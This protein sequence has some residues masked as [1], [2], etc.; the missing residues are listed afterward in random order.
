[1]PGPQKGSRI[2]VDRARWIAALVCLLL[3]VSS[4]HADPD[5]PGPSANLEL[6]PAGSLVIAMDNAK[7][8]VGTP[9]NLKAYGLVNDLLWAGIPVK[10][11]IRAGKA[12]D[13]TDFTVTAQRIYPSAVAAASLN[14]SAGPFIIHRDWAYYAKTRIAA[15]GNSVAVY[16]TTQDVTVDIRHTLQFRPKIAVLNDGGNQNIHTTYLSDAG[17]VATTHYVTISATTLTTIN[18]DICITAASEPHWSDTPPDT[19]AAVQAVLAFLGS[20]GNFLAECDGIQ[21]YENNPTYGRYQSTT[22]I[23]ENSLSQSFLYPNPD[24]PISQFD[25]VLVNQGGSIG[26]FALAAGSSWRTRTYGIAQD[27]PTTSTYAATATKLNASGIGSIAAYLGGHSYDDNSTDKANGRR[28]YL[29]WV[30]TPSARPSSCGL[31]MVDEFRQISGRVY[32]DVNGDGNLGDGVNAANVPI[33]IYADLN[34]N[35]V[36]DTGDTYIGQSATLADGT[37]SL[38][39]NKVATGNNYVVVVDS[40]SIVP[41]GGYNGGFAIGDVWAEQTYGDDPTTAALDVAAR[42]GGASGTVSDNFNP[43]LAAVASNS[44]QHVARVSVASGD[45]PNVNFGFS[46]N[47]VVNTRAGDAVDD[48]ATANRTVQ[49]SFRQFLRNAN[50]IAGAN[51]M[52][53]TPAVATNATGGGGNWWRIS[54]TTALPALS[55]ANT[56]ID[57]RAYSS[58]DGTTVRDDNSGTLGTGGTAGTG[59]LALSTLAKPEFEIQD[60]RATAVIPVGLDIQGS[61]N[62]IRRIGILGFGAASDSANDSDIRIGASALRALVEDNLIGTAASTF[63]DAGAGIRSVGDHIRSSGGDTGIIR[64]NLIGFG[65]GKGVGLSTASDGWLVEG[66]EI[67]R[68]AIGN[69]ALDGVDV[70]ASTTATVRGNLIAQTDGNGIDTNASTGS[71]T[72]VNNT[73]TGNGIGAAALETSGIRIFGAGS[74]IDRNIVTANT[75]A[76]VLVTVAATTNRITHNSIS[77]NGPSNNQIGIDLLLAG[78]DA[79]RGTSPFVS[80]NDNT[81]P[82]VGGNNVLNYPVIDTA[83]IRGTDLVLRGWARPGSIIELF[84]AAPDPSNFGEGQT[85]LI[86]LTEGSGADTDATSSIFGPGAVNGIVQG[87]DNTNRFRFVIPIASLTTPVVDGTRIT[88]TATDGS[89]NTSEFSGLGTVFDTKT[90][91][92]VTKTDGVTSAIPGNSITY[93]ITVTNLGPHEATGA[94]LTDTFD[95][96]F[97]TVAGVSWTCAITTGSGACGAASGTGNISTGVDLTLNSVATFT[98]TA[99]IKPQ[100]TG[101]ISNTAT[102]TVAAG[103]IDP[104]PG[105]N[106]ATDNNTVL[107]VTAN[108]SITKTDGVVTAIPG[109]SVT[110]TLV[111]GN[112]GPSTAVNA[113]VTDTFNPAMFNVAGVSWT[114]VIAGSGSCGAASGTGNIATT[115]TLDPSATATYTVTAPILSGATGTLSNTATVAAPAG[116][117]DPVAGNNS[118]TDNNTVLNPSSDLSITKTDG[119]NSAIPGQSIT[120]TIVVSNAG[121][122]DTVNASVTDALNPVQFNLPGTSWTCAVTGSGSCGAAS[123]TGSIASTVSLTVGSSATYTVTAPIRANATGTL[124]NTATVAAP[125][126]ASDP[127]AGNNSATDNN[128]VLNV[129]SDLSI[130]KTDGVV[131]AVPGQ[132]VTYTIVVSNAGPSNTVNAPVADTFNPA[133]FNVAGV[134]WTCAITGTGSC[135]AASGTGN[136]ATTVSLSPGSS[137]TYTVTAPILANATGTL[138]N[139]A[140][141][142]APAGS[143]DPAAGNNSATDNNTVL[144]VT[145]DLSITK[146]DGVASATPGQSVTYTIVVANGGPSNVVNAAVADT[147]NASFFNVAGVSWTCAI[148]GTGSCGAASGTGNIATTVSLNSGSSATYTVTAPILASATGTLSNTATV[149]APGGTTDPAAGN[150]SATDNNT[151]LSPVADLSITKTDGVVS[152][153]A[154]QSVTYTIVVSNAGPSS[155]VNAPVADTF[156]PAMFNVGGVSWTCA[157]SGSGS[158][159]AASGSGNIATTASIAPGSTATYTVTAPILAAATGTLSNTA[160]V[161]APGGT[162]D[163]VAGNNSATDNN[164]VLSV[165]SD[166]SITKTDG[167]VSAVAGQSVTYT[168]VV[169]NAGPSSV[170]NAPVADTFNPAMFNVAGVSWTCAITGTGSC[171]AASGTGNIATTVSLAPGSSATY[172]VTAPILASATGTLSNT[173]TVSAPGGTTDPVNGNNSATDNNTVLTG[174]ADL[175]I[176]KTDGVASAIPGQSVTYTLVVSNAGPSTVVGAAVTDTF[177]PTKFNVAAVSWTCATSGGGS[178][179]AASGTGNLATTASLPPGATAT[180]TMTAPILSAATGTLSNTASVAAPAGTNDPNGGNNSATD[181]NTALQVTTDLSVVKSDGV[182]TAV[183]GQSVTY[184]ITVANAGPSNAV[185]AAVADTFNPAMFNVGGVS[186][187][188]AITGSGSCGAASGTGNIATTVS[189]TAGSSATYTVTV[190]ILANA[191]GTLSNT[192]TVAAAGGTTDPVAGNNS[193]TDNNTALQATSNLAIT[194]DD[195]AASYLPGGTTIYTITVTNAGPSDAVDAVVSDPVT[196]LPEVASASWTCAGHGGA[197]CTAGPV[198]GVINDTVDIPVGGTVIYTLT[199]ITLPGATTNLVNTATVAAGN[200]GVDPSNGDNSDTDTDTKGNGLADVSIT[201][202]DGV[203]TAVAGQSVTYTIVV[204]NAGP[205]DVTAADVTDTFDPTWFNV[206]GV[207]WTC[208][209][210]GTGACAAGAGSGNIATT[211]DLAAGSTATFTVTAPILSGATGTIVNTAMVLAPS[212]TV[213]PNHGNDAATDNNTVL[214]RI[215]DL[216]ITKTDGVASAV[217]GQSVTYTIVV[218]NAGPSNVTN[219]AVADTFNPAMFNVAGESWTCAVTGSG[220]CGAASGT[221]NIATT[222]SLT[223]GSSATYTVTAPILSSATGTL[224]NTATVAAPGG[225]TDPVAGNNSATD[226]NTALSVTADLS[227]TK[228]DGVASAVP[229]QSVTYTIVVAN[230]G[231]S[232]VVNAPVADTFNPAMF[233]VAG[234]SW[235]CAVTGTGSCGAASGTGNIATTVSL[236]SGAS[237]TYTVT[238]P[239]LSIATGTLSNTA[240]VA[241]PSGATDAV[242][243]NNSATD[244]DTALSVTA[245]LSITKTDGVASAVPG[246]SVTYTIVVSNAGPSDAVNAAVADTFDPSFFNVGGVSW[247]CLVT[248]GGSCGAAS[249]TGNIATTVSL[250]SGSAATYTVTAPILS[251]ATGTPSNTATVAAPGGTTDPVAG[252]NSATDNNTVLSVTADLSIT[253]TDGVASAVPGQSVTYTIVVA[254]NGP[255]DVV[256]APVADT[257]DPT[258][259]NVAGVSWTCAT[260]GPGSCGAASGSGNIATTVSLA[261]G[262]SATYTVTAPILSNATGTLSNTATVTAPG[263]TTDPV[264][265]NNTATDN[266]TALSVTSD[267]SI[268]KTDGVASAVPGQSVTYTIVVANNGP[269]DVVNAPVADTFDPTKFNVAGV[270][271]TCTVTGTGSCGAASGTGNIATTV[272]LT[273]GSSATYTVTAP[274]LSSATGTLSNTATV[275]APAGTTDPAAGNNSATDNNTALSVTADLSI[276]KTDGVATAVPGQSVTYTIV[277]SNSGPSDVVNAPVADTFDA[278]KFNVAGVSWTCAV[279]GPGSCGAASGTGNI[280]STVTLTSGSSATYTVTA[281]ILA[282]ATGTLSNTAT[283]A[284]PGGTTDPVA[285]NNS[286]TD[287]DTA[288]SVTADLSITKTDG[289]ATAVPGQSVTYTIAVSNAGPSNVV[290]APVA[291]TLNPAMFNVGGSSWTCVVTGGGSCGAASGTGSIASTVDL[292]PGATA[293]YTV[294]VPILSGATG[295]LSNTA[296]VAAPGGTTDPVAGNNSATDNDTVLSVTADLAITKTDGVASAVPGQSVTYTIVVSNN[297]PSDVVNAAVADTFDPARFN[298]AGATWTCAVTG[299]GSCAAPSGTGNIATAVSLTSGSS[300]TYTVTVPILSSATGTL[301]NTATVTAPGGTTDPVAGNNSA[302]DNDTALSVTADLS[303]TKTDGVASAVPGQSVT[304]TIVVANAGPSDV[305]NAPVA[306]TF[307]PALFNIAGVSWTCAVT[308]TGSCGAASGTGNIASTVSLSSGSSATYTVTAPILSN[309]TGT[310]SNTATIAAPAGT[311]DPVAGNNSATD[312]DTALSVT[313]DLS[314]TK[315]DGVVSAVPGQSVTY[316]I[317]VS[318]AGPSDVINAPVADTF[319]PAMFNVAGVSWTCVVTGGGS[320]GAASG[321]GNIASTASLTSGSSA[322]YTVTAPILA[323]ATG[324]LSNTATITAPAGTIDPVAGNNSA[325]DNNTALSVTADLSIT[326]TDG[327]VSAMPGQTVTYTIVV[328]NAGPSNVVNATV[329]DVFAPALFNA[330]GASWTCA[331]TGTG[332]CGAASGAGNLAT[333]VSLTIGSSAT[334]TVTV[335]IL[336]AATGTLSNTATVAAPAGATDPVAG[337]NSATDNDTVL[338]VTADLSITKTDG[339]VS[340]VPGQSVTY[341]I[342][343]AN[344]GLS[345]VVNAAIADAFDP[346]K[347][348]VGAVSWTCA[349]TGTGACGAASGTGNIATTVS[350]T[351]GSSATYT[352]TAP[353]LSN[354]TGTLSNTATVAAP[355]GTT[356]PVAGNNTATDNDT[357]LSVT[358]DLSITKTDGV[359]SAVPGQTITYTIVVSNAGPSD[360]VNASVADAF[361]PAMFNVAGVS[362]TCAVTGTGAC[363]A[364]SGTG[365]IATTLSLTSSSSATYIVTVPILSQATGTL[366]N[367]A[368]VAAPAGTTDPVAGNN[369]AT[370]SD[371][372]LNGVADLSITKTDGVASAVPGQSVT[373]TIVVS[374]NGP[375]NVVGAPV[376]DTFNPAQFNVAGVSWTCAVAGAG[377]CSAA[378]GTGNIATSVDLA[379]GASATYTVTAPILP[380][381]TGTLANTATVATPAGTSD[382]AP[383]NNTATDNNTA[384]SVTADL[385]ITKTDGVVSAVPGQ[386]VTYTI[387][388]ANAGPSSVAAAPVTDTFNPAQFNVAG[389]SWTCAIAGVGAC[390]AA[391]GTGN[392]ATTVNLAPGATATYTVTAPIRSSATGTLSNTALVAAPAGTTDPVAGNNTATDN[393]TALSVTADLAI[394]KTDGVVAAVPGQSVTY[395][396]IVTNSGPSDVVNAAVADTFNPALFNVAGVSWTCAVTGTG[397][398]GAASGTGNIAT[399]VSLTSGSSATY[400]VTV[401]ILSNATGS[402]ANTATVTAPAGTTDPVAGNNSATDNDT[403]LNAA[404]DLSITKTDGVASAVPGQ[405]VTYTIVVSNAGPSSVVAAPVN[406]AFN[407]AQFNIAGISWTCAVTGTGSC[408]AASGTGNIATT[409]DLAPGAFATYTV[410]APILAS[411]TGT[412]SNTATVTAPP[413]TTDSVPG[414]NSATDNNTVLTGVADLSITKTDGVVSAVAGQ[415]VTY[416]IVVSNAGPSSVVA[417]PVADTFNPA[418]FNV[419]GVSWTCAITGTGACGAASGTGNLATTVDL[420]PGSSATYTVTAPI[421]PGATGTLSNTATVAA[422]AGTTDPVAGNNSATDNN[423]ALSVTADL[424]ITKT[425]G[426][427]T[428]APGQSVTYTIVV[429]NA[430]PSSVVGAPVTDTFNPVFFNVAG[431]SWTCAIAGTGACGAASGTGNIATTVDLAPGATATYTVTAPVRSNATGTLSN[432]ATV[433]VPVGTTDPVAGN[434]T[435]TDSNTV[436]SVTSDL[437]ITKT[438]GVVSAVPGQSVTFTIVVTNNGPSDVIGAPVADTFNPAMFDVASVSWTCAAGGGGACG[439]ASGTGNIATTVSLPTG[440]SATFTVNA[441]ILASATGTLSNTATVTAPIGTTDPVAGNNAATDNNTVL[442]GTSDLSITKTDGVVSAA[443]GQS[444]TYTIVVANAGPS[445]VTNAPI[446]DTF[447]PAQF[448][449]AAVSWTCAVTGTGS[450]AAASGTGNIATTVSLTTGSLATFT[451]TAPIL[452]TATGTLSNTATVGV[453]LGSVDPNLSNNSATDNNTALNVTADLSI[454]KTDGVVSAVP[455]QSVTY[456]IVVGNA[457]PSNIVAAPVTDPFNPAQFNV[458]GITWTCAITGTGACGAASGSGNIAT[459]V[460]LAPGATATYTVTAPILSAATGTLSNTAT[461]AL[462]PGTTDP[463]PGNNSATDNDTVLGVRADLSITK[464]DGVA[465]AVPGQSV[466]YTIVVA[467]AGPSDVVNANVADTLNPGWFNVAGATWTCAVTGTGACGA[468]SG[469]GNIATT[470]S[471]TSGSSA[472]YLVTVPIL[473]SATGTLSNT[474]TVTAPAGTTDPAAGN[475]SATD[476][477]TSLD[478]SFDLS[479]TKTDS[480]VSAVPGQTVTYT[481]VVSNAG[482]SDVVNAAV[483]DPFNPAVFNVAGVNWTCAITGGG[484]C[485]AASGTG[486]IATTVSLTAGSSAT[487]IV[488]APILPSATGTLS[489]TATVTAAVGTVDRAPGNNSATDNDTALGAISD[490]AITK[491]DGVVS[492]LPGTSVT[493]TVVVTNAGPSDVVGAAVND[494]F[495]VSRFNVA[496]V[497]WTCTITGSGACGAPVG[498]GNLATTVRLT[499]GSSATYTVIAPIL[500][501]ATGVLANT[502]TVAPP[503]GT[504]DP[505]AGNNTATDNDTALNVT[506]DLSITKTDGVVNAVAGQSVT[507]TIRVTNAGPAAAVDAAVSDVLNATWFNV[508]GATWSCAITTPPGNCDTVSGA[509]SLAS[510]VDLG[511]NAVATF[512]VTAPIS[513]TASGTIVNT[514]TVTPAAGTTDPTPGNNSATDNDTQ[515]GNNVDL[516]LTK[517]VDNSTPIIG[518][519]VVFTVTVANAIGYRPATGVVV[520]D[521]LPDGYVYVA[522]DGGGSYVPATGVWTVGT[523]ASG[524]SRSLQIT[525]RVL[526]T[527]NHVNAAEV[528]AANEPDANDVRGDGTGGDFGSA[529]VAPRGTDATID[530]TDTSLPGDTLTVTVNDADANRDP[531]VVETIT[532]TVVNDATG[533]GETLILTE[534]GPNTGVFTGTLPTVFDTLAGPANDGLMVTRHGDTVTA[535]YQDVFT[536]AGGSVMRTDT[537]IVGGTVVRIAKTASED[538]VVVGDIVPYTIRVE[539]ITT[540]PLNNVTISDRIPAGFKLV[541]SSARLIRAG[542]DTQLGTVDDVVTPLPTTGDRPVDFGPLALA[543]SEVVLL[544]YALRVGSGAAQGEHVNQAAPY[545]SGLGVGTSSSASVLVV[546]DPTFDQ[547]TIIGRVFED[548]DGDGRFTPGEPGVGKAMVALDDGTYALT[549]EDGRFHF[550]A[551]DP[552]QRMVKLNL[553]SLPPGSTASGEESHILSLT[554]GLMAKANFGVTIARHS[555][556]TAN[557]E[558]AALALASTPQPAPIEVRGSAEAL[559]ALVNGTAVKIAASDARLRVEPLDDAITLVG[560]GLE[561]PVRFEIAADDS[562]AVASWTLTVTDGHGK[563]VRTFSGEGKPPESIAWDGRSDAGEMLAAGE[564]YQYRV[565]TRRDNGEVFG[566]PVRLFGVNRRTAVAF[567]LSGDTFETGSAVLGDKAKAVLEDVAKAFREFPDEKVVVEGHTDNI[568]GDAYNLELS[569]RRA[570]AAIHYLVD[571]LGLPE[572]QFIARWYGKRRPLATNTQPE[573]RAMNR[574]VEI[575]G[576][577]E[578]V[579]GTRATAQYQG[580]PS[581]KIN[582]SAVEVGAFGRFAGQ[583][584]DPAASRVA[585]EM[586][587]SKGRT[588]HTEVV[589]PSIEIL[590]PAGT[591]TVARGA[592]SGTCK[593]SPLTEFAAVN[594]A[595]ADAPAMACSLRGRTEPGNVVEIDGKP[596]TVAA[597]GSFGTAVVLPLGGETIGLVVRNPQ[598]FAR[599]ANVD[600]DVSDREADG[601]LRVVTEAIPFVTVNLPPNGTKLK[602]QLLDVVGKTEPG[603]EIEING[604]RQEVGPDGR[605]AATLELPPGKNHLVVKVRDASGREGIIERDVDVVKHE[606]FLMAFADGTFGQMKSKGLVEA[607]GIDPNDSTYTDGRVAYYLKGTIAGKYLVTSAFDSGHTES[608]SAF[609]GLDEETSRRLLTNLDPDKIYPVY[610]DESEVVYDAESEGKFYLALDSDELHVLIGNYPLSLSDNELAAYRR[611]LYGA[612]MIYQSSAKTSYGEPDTQVIAFGAEVRYAHVRDEIDATGGSLYYLSHREAVEGSEEVT[613]VIR[614]VNTGLTLATQRQQRNIDYTMKY[615][616]GR[617]V[618][619]RPISSVVDSGSLVSPT[620]LSGHPVRIQVDYETIVNNLDKTASGTRVRQQVNDNVAVGATYVKDELDSGRHELAGLDAEVHVGKSTRFVAEYASSEGTDSLSFVSI[621]GGITYNAVPT[622]GELSGSAWR[623]AA[624]MDLGA[625]FGHPDRYN[626]RAYFKKLD[627][628]FFAS[629]TFLEQGTEKA[630]VNA[631]LRVTD[632]DTVQVRLDREQR[633]GNI[634]PTAPDESTIGSVQWNHTAERWGVAAEYQNN[635]TKDATGQSLTRNAFGAVKL[636]TKITEKFNGYLQHQETLS[637]P[638]NDQTT[639]GVTYQVAKSVALDFRATDGTLGQSAELGAV[640]KSGDTDIYLAQRAA[641]D[642]AGRKNTTVLGARSPLG[643]STKV[644]GEYQWEDADAGQRKT[645]LVGLQRKWDVTRGLKF[646]MAGEAA[647][648][649]SENINTSR[650]AISAAVSHSPS[651]RLVTVG[652]GEVRWERSDRRRIQL[653]ASLQTDYKLNRDFTLLGKYRFS[654]TEDQQSSNLEAKFEEGSVGVA[655]RP[656]ANDRFNGLARFTH[657]YEL[658][659]TGLAVAAPQERTLDVLSAEGIYDFGNGIEWFGKL[660]ARRQE[661]NLEIDLSAKSDSWLAIQRVNWM[662]RKPWEIGVEYRILMQR[663]ADDSRQGFLT[664]AMWS[665]HKNFR[666]GIGYN[667][668]D[669]SDNE[670]SLNDYSVHGWFVRAQARY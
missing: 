48:D 499:V 287:N 447:N 232:D 124:S 266:N 448:N 188:C 220:S 395:T 314:I 302:T 295:T 523:V 417:A 299:S 168:I 415:S 26:D 27:T 334:Y 437:S 555:A 644:Y 533:E 190:P 272:S 487:Y 572:S 5:L 403:A 115:V 665:L 181:N 65:Q 96:A 18:A 10:W 219:A 56:T 258:K 255:S 312:N 183:P 350:L 197:S 136:I 352:V 496:G 611:T 37:Y 283:I 95:P 562:E 574:R 315:T 503:S 267:L 165:T 482:P 394:T 178:C 460:D 308:G 427:A 617:I 354:A 224:S 566:S 379:P 563:D 161:A 370:D 525:A 619:N 262:S 348:N 429:A 305:V 44:Y 206:A 495:D 229:G 603:N 613:I 110:Y 650:T 356:D 528:T 597:D 575:K 234:V 75:G 22:G 578:Q 388:V 292:A 241:A 355:A 12:K 663:Q 649:Q 633:S 520:S 51:V 654:K 580:S 320:C 200:G 123:G 20:G 509:G 474:A 435:A 366:S 383:G 130:T 184:T 62:T 72:I 494:I 57:G 319:N 88:A 564:V 638:S 640:V 244:N 554:P 484:S 17:F 341:T 479:I 330:A 63:T 399:T 581:V 426:V 342:V 464:T 253:K 286:A 462:P 243:G 249:G 34:N 478:P 256:N 582:G 389:V 634:V 589:V 552:G 505:V 431:V 126:G 527:G 163:P 340:A 11:A 270:S 347:F 187:T 86:D 271:W 50:A 245:D 53:F 326:K 531:S 2:R 129:T 251:N 409:V 306:D 15:F 288:L 486:S 571:D 491:T 511:V 468:A 273:T 353:I 158:C 606:L 473:S 29:N 378:S 21:A 316:T 428:A 318:N 358:A 33:R 565:E 361:N 300:A 592:A 31:V 322:T 624:E 600:F 364:A 498:T 212:G 470:V 476:S 408:G 198:V 119:V 331:V 142:S 337:N 208:G 432:T 392:L 278:A 469:A 87:T 524:A 514:A 25:G 66:N 240:T 23:E 111:V 58:T 365:N 444:V 159:G 1:M 79:G 637:G 422:P 194:K 162:S 238:A 443:P 425:D 264:A 573:G 648:V 669:F 32:E 203:A 510:T 616:E 107:N 405:S 508:P 359:I 215:A 529:S 70:N 317:L 211:V 374:N 94:T 230:A 532:V 344:N 268:T 338:S 100:A 471:L 285:G 231:P 327:V 623:A 546:A 457:G 584:T 321:T 101:T 608:G 561:Q 173:A 655:Y 41:T 313:A 550:P 477:D 605:F 459:A 645:S 513:V 336:S 456:T 621:D 449:V 507:Y 290:G 179:G 556:E 207:S 99:P 76:G 209:I 170:V 599:I 439:A 558:V 583:V 497:S 445:D 595:G 157:I 441:P 226:N 411:A 85:W 629:G 171:G 239:I 261:S 146:T 339:V 461:V 332:S 73:V 625:A 118:A 384:L 164:T 293:T 612:R 328:A 357:A 333:T 579:E 375:S 446:A 35:G 455:G 452:A 169:S 280:A 109:Q 381:A 454:T 237:A 323:A 522:D 666:L 481:I 628:G 387:V 424:S 89:N 380:S 501:T 610:G 451:V 97:F 607:A 248:G 346:T 151:A 488:N 385:S 400:T 450:C 576:E 547:S 376:A 458:A 620:I 91:L 116:T 627:P 284:A 604:M 81:D 156:N 210:G 544:R 543:P 325:T 78:N 438:D 166:L 614:D 560:A 167:V 545:I 186:W 69:T 490:L 68:N 128:T 152:A 150:N 467:N 134:S 233:N 180:Y 668:T 36:A 396:V 60:I 661:R 40:K 191:T 301:S 419:A 281:P 84:I 155:A 390:S 363:G 176:T 485:G 71:N 274:I 569:K 518:T 112:A 591:V 160:T 540:V 214:T 64:R 298:A 386:S 199:V 189:L 515:I 568:G 664:E 113:P 4:V 46:F 530:I 329:A 114:C 310:L 362:W 195:G 82:D 647:E 593:A 548:L 297:G 351:S 122:S 418:Q 132:S 657:L 120:Y 651:D 269:S 296:T 259:F 8:N 137:A 360:V 475:N 221:G 149:T 632:K 106:A 660:A 103:T 55:D 493:Y 250:T 83:L 311:T 105:N 42:F 247:T 410:T 144:N 133:L 140:T 154:G 412:L 559:T 643:P 104:V 80:L 601:T 667:F 430:G 93:T 500:P 594:A 553:L 596:V 407:P 371:T 141:V 538:Y 590:E 413:G 521:L 236:A 367:T 373:Y 309:A 652:R 121:P 213:D 205:S 586:V 30:L 335:P 492:A 377:A 391:S 406:D 246:Q 480:T 175:S 442:G 227:I 382:P 626:A 539:N 440:S 641:E 24:L 67:R 102:A 235:T 504:T 174:T 49:G 653:F 277:V 307:N 145:A 423:T 47:A 54:V 276:T 6:I 196:A 16:E 416:T 52:R 275:A 39:V 13:A 506:L 635:D 466:T 502:A 670:F 303:I 534:T 225:T 630:G 217:P 639:A 519:T 598:G 9:F 368:T 193:S 172:T 185:N 291:D 585:I 372:A 127:V 252:N 421:Q 282:V 463:V 19:N 402:L 659:P 542:V 588:V 646:V 401:P 139:T 153:V 98:V 304:Y 398:C 216:S 148:T 257:F 74:T 618:F 3:A 294:T 420:A 570:E 472:T 433:A 551:V 393:D 343:V 138:S 289:V 7:Q 45:V 108:L 222:V 465:T 147:F 61:D 254:N 202:T 92:V 369:T 263:G 324:T 549:D 642:R 436:L 622:T 489:N 182:V 135:G 483:A 609:R 125:A 615:P 218:A 117:T 228:T 345:D 535:S 434:N 43:T 658:T 59:A 177:D 204:S 404:A 526:A 516:S 587:D 536:A 631:D 192:A 131:S 662:L 557:R 577:K 223:S 512:T 537:G 77:G 201:K 14:F 602:S 143:T 90:D 265:G 397:A 279:T 414:N 517:T 38:Q 28:I 260:T 349:V 656:V 453:P 567:Q 636:W 541:E 242:A